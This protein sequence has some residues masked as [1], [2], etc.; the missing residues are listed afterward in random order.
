MV[1]PSETFGEI[2]VDYNHVECSSACVTALTAF[3]ARHPD[4]RADEIARSL[5]RG[6]KYLKRCAYCQCYRCLCPAGEVGG[7]LRRGIRH[8]SAARCRLAPFFPQ[9]QPLPC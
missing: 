2:M 8:H 5:R 9:L 1:N 7:H 3:R 4:H 6:I